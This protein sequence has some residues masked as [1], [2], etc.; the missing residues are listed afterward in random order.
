MGVKDDATVTMKRIYFLPPTLLPVCYELDLLS[1]FHSRI[2]HIWLRCVRCIT[3]GTRYEVCHLLDH[4]GCDVRDSGTE[5]SLIQLTA[6]CN[7]P[8][9]GRYCIITAKSRKIFHKK[10]NVINFNCSYSEPGSDSAFYFIGGCTQKWACSLLPF[11]FEWNTVWSLFSEK[12][13]KLQTDE[14]RGWK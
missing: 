6:N 7:F 1:S 12:I 2:L 9:P 3:E 4:V 8:I 14:V 10:N 5:R 11:A 13:F